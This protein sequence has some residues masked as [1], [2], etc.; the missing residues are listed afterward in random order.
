MMRKILL[1][2]NVKRQKEEEE[3]EKIVELFAQLLYD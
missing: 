1:V 3:K 2:E